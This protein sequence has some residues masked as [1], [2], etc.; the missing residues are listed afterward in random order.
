MFLRGKS[1]Y[2]K[3]RAGE[4]DLIWDFDKLLSEVEGL[5]FEKIFI[6]ATKEECFERL[7]NDSEREDKGDWKKLI[8]EWFSQHG[9]KPQNKSAR[10]SFW[11][12]VRNEAGERILRIEGMIGD[13]DSWCNDSVTPQKFRNELNLGANDITVWINSEGGD[14]WAGVQIYNMLKEYPGKVTI[15][16]DA[17]AGSAASIIAMAGDAVEISPAGMIMIHNPWSFVEGDSAQMQSVAIMLDEVKENMITIYEKK[18]KLPRDEIARMMDEETWLH[19]QK[20]VE[21]GFADKI[22]GDE[23]AP[24]IETSTRRQVM[25]CLAKA[26]QARTARGNRGAKSPDYGEK[27][28]KRGKKVA[29]LRRHLKL[30]ES[31]IGGINYE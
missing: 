24:I 12:F 20:A 3:E 7:K 30:I 17:I 1:N 10:K 19:A 6:E 9:D 11:R 14:F 13:N 21:F 2:V 28:S 23:P 22:I 29:S 27:N 25:N 8:N 18:T 31:K 15:K 5:D 4:H 16:I 26:V